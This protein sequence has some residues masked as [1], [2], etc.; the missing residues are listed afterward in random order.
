MKLYLCPGTCSVAP[1][2]ALEE[3]G[4]AYET[5]LVDLRTKKTAGGG[6]Y[7]ATNGKGYV[8]ALQLDDGE[9]LTEVPIIVQY[10][11]DLAPERHLAPP[12]GSKERRRLQEWLNFIGAELHKG[13][14]PLFN[15]KM[16]AEGKAAIGERLDLRLG[17][18]DAA[19]AKSSYLLGES[20]T[21]A[22]TYL[23]AVLRWTKP[24]QI[25]LGRWPSLRAY[26]EHIAQRPAVQTVLKAEGLAG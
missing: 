1:H 17:Y 4:L 6:D 23:Y 3:A 12:A 15:P 19:L 10:I 20:F 5:E 16:P 8:P 7:L 26:F 25:D 22:D 18:V 2:V 11:A 9:L 13:F 14:G 24:M 21:V